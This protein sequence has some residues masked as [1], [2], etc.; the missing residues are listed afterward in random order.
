MRYDAV[1][2]R[3]R[4]L[5]DYALK[6][7]RTQREK[8]ERGEYNRPSKNKKHSAEGSADHGHRRGKEANDSGREMPG[9]GLTGKWLAR[10]LPL[11]LEGRGTS[12][13]LV[14]GEDVG[15]IRVGVG[16]ERGEHQERMR[17]RVKMERVGGEHEESGSEYSDGSASD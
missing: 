7:A 5:W 11:P 15:G 10:S 3:V 13:T 2:G 8:R 6:G 4:V 1:L 9:S 14:E 12:G 16:V 17:K